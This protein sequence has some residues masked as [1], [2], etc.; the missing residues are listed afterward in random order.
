MMIKTVFCCVVSFLLIGCAGIES[1]FSCKATATG[2]CQT[3]T[4]ANKLSQ[5]KTSNVKLINSQKENKKDIK[6]DLTLIDII[7]E[8]IPD[9]T[10]EKVYKIWIAPYVDDKDNFH[11]EQSIF[12]TSE[13]TR[14]AGF[15]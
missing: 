4:D 5:Q 9:R 15:E 7:G 1:D 12:F 2:S 6:K 13:P 8:S 3:M 14:W 11:R 10:T